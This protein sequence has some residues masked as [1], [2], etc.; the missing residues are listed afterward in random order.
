MGQHNLAGSAGGTGLV[1]TS[2]ALLFRAATC[3]QA[4][5]LPDRDLKASGG[6]RVSPFRGQTTMHLENGAQVR[7]LNKKLTMI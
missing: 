3:A 4:G 1:T 7:R 2:A 6:L 5:L